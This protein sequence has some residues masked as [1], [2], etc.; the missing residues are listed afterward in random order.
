MSSIPQR[1]FSAPAACEPDDERCRNWSRE[2]L[3]AMDARFAATLE[4]AFELGLE[5]ISRRYTLQQ[6]L[7]GGLF[8]ISRT[9]RPADR[10]QRI[11]HLGVFSLTPSPP[12]ELRND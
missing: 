7:A 6:L 4:R 5:S 9:G 11:S 12:L 3:E 1:I 8:A 10:E 2:E